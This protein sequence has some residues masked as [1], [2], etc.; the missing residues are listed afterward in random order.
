MVFAA[1]I[2]G[3]EHS[4]YLTFNFEK[5]SFNLTFNLLFFRL[6]T[7]AVFSVMSLIG[8]IGSACIAGIVGLKIMRT[9][10]D[11]DGICV[12]PVPYESSADD[13]KLSVINF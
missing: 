11:I 10:S 13:C 5:S 9:L 8:A 12:P 3:R 1:A 6:I 2:R 7:V 4:N